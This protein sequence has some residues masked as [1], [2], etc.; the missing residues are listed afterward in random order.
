MPG[1]ILR[2]PYWLKIQ[3]AGGEDYK[4]LRQNLK[5]Q[6]LHT[7]CEEAKCPNLGECWSR[8]VATVMILGDTCT[9][10][11]SFCNVKTGRP[12]TYDR[13][14]PI[15]V[16]RSV[17]KMNLK[18]VTIT[19]V[20]RDD[21]PDLGSEVWA[22]TILKVRELCPTLHIEVLIPD[23]QGKTKWVDAVLEAGPDVLNHNMETVQ[24]LQKQIRKFA[25]WE[26]SRTVLA[27][28]KTKGFV[29]K[30]GIMVGLG[31]TKEEVLEYIAQMRDLQVDILSIGQ[32]LQPSRQHMPVER[33]V[34][35]TE[36]AEYKQHALDLGIPRCESGPLV[37]SS[38][39]A[40]DQAGTLVQSHK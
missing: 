37:R 18:Y 2:K 40:E 9:R 8:G 20:D 32:Y 28:A 34:D 14:E 5:N 29:T 31:E 17:Q 30:T 1:K 26:F 7:V 22:E 4:N 38:Y 3:V 36:F 27:H 15:R 13:S 10:A 11:C 12:G 19:S 25:N 6:N 35:P 21:L 23:F 39:H 33:Y 16:A 24:R